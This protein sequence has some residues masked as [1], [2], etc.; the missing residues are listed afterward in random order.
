[1][2]DVLPK[3][4]ATWDRWLHLAVAVAVA[5]A[6]VA[7]TRNPYILVAGGIVAGSALVAALTGF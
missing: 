5:C 2:E 1:M 6:A 3:N 7:W 4:T